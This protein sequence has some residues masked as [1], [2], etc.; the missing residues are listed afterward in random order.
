MS[1]DE[2]GAIRMKK[3]ISIPVTPAEKKQI[4]EIAKENKE[5]VVSTLLKP[6]GLK[7]KYK[8]R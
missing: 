2:K 4:K 7:G 5:T 6:F 8:K 1:K 3:Q